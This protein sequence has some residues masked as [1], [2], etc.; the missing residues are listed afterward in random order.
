MKPNR[1]RYS[2][3]HLMLGTKVFCLNSRTVKDNHFKKQV[4]PCHRRSEGMKLRI[5]KKSSRTRMLTPSALRLRR[6]ESFVKKASV[7]SLNAVEISRA[8]GVRIA[9][10]A[11][12]RAASFAMV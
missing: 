2:S 4:I 12:R 9:Y 7:F 6:R 11:R 5:Y 8:S 1:R 10:L 3:V